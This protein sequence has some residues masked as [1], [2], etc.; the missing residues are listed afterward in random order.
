MQDVQITLPAGTLV[1]DRYKVKSLIGIGHGGAVYLV[2]DQR[3]KPTEQQVYALKEIIGLS[4]QERDQFPFE[5][6]PLRHLHHLR[7]P[8]IYHVFNDD[9]RSRVYI[10]MD[11][12]DGPDLE[13][14]WQQ[15]EYQFTW[16]EISLIMTPIFDAVI[17]LHR[18]EPPIVHG[19]IKPINIIMSQPENSYMLVDIGSA[20]ERIPHSSNLLDRHGYRAPEQYE[21][22]GNIRDVRVDV[23]GL[24]ATCYTLL[25]DVVPPNALVRVSGLEQ[26]QTDP[27]KPLDTLVPTIPAHISRAIHRSLSIQP[28]DRFSSVEEFWQALR[29]PSQE[30]E[31]PEGVNVS[32]TGAST[33]DAT[34]LAQSPADIQTPVRFTQPIWTA[35]RFSLSKGRALTLVLLILLLL[36]AAGA[37]FWALAQSRNAALTT[38][39]RFATAPAALSTPGAGS[40]ITIVTPTSSPGNYP[41]VV[42]T[43]TGTLVD[44]S[45]K[46]SPTI[47]LQGIHQVGGTINGYFTVGPPFNISGPFMG[48][49]DYTKH[50][51][52]TVQDAAAHPVLFV[53]G[54]IQSAASLSGAYYRCAATT[55]PRATCTRAAQG[56]GIWNAQRV[57]PTG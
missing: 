25:T 27:L 9:K 56:Y 2:N 14:L 11:F 51:Q 13:T 36:V 50:F 4:K 44:L 1:R 28:R 35:L 48:T 20:R 33:P 19:D 57:T 30:L 22:G 24:G 12:V 7:L 34:E 15:R 21:R 31:P 45:T 5:S 29:I 49:I 8:R 26:D 42:G 6:I 54:D 47:I 39:R 18:R 32:Q 52:F 38:T 55:T 46:S 37:G 41:S 16:P 10:V 3:A 17:Y 53:E 43:Y 40:T 23:Y